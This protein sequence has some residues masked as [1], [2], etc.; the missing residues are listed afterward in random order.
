MLENPEPE[1]K[2]LAKHKHQDHSPAGA[3]AG[4][5]ELCG[6]RGVKLTDMRR[7]V[8]KALI[9]SNKALGAYDLIEAAAVSGKRRPAPVQI[10]RALDFLMEH[11][12]AH[13]IES[14]NAFVA[15][16]HHHAAHETV[17]FFICEAC[18]RVQEEASEAMRASL[19]TLAKKQRFRPVSN[20]IE[21]AGRCA[22]C[23]ETT[24]SA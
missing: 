20:I 21:V 12:L 7:A 1:A 22:G 6:K 3:L 5:D 11:G 14:R 17:V 8:L 19:A 15:C 13:R 10:Y 4:A 23:V 2:A 18:N 16:P 24:L 9:G